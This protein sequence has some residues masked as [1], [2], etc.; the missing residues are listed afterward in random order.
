MSDRLPKV[1]AEKQ[2]K[3]EAA[4]KAA[5]G[6]TPE[7]EA[8]LPDQAVTPAVVDTAPAP[9]PGTGKGESDGPEGR[10]AT[11]PASAMVP[12]ETLS[13]FGV[14]LS[15]VTVQTGPGADK[16]CADRGAVAYA[17][18]STIVVS[19]SAGSPGS[20]EFLKI[21]GH[22]LTHVVQQRGGN[23]ED[24]GGGNAEA[25][26]D[27][28]GEAAAK[29][30]AASVGVS[31]PSGGEQNKEAPETHANTTV[32]KIP[33]PGGKSIEIEPPDPEGDWSIGVGDVHKFAKGIGHKDSKW[34]RKSIPTPFFGLV[35][36]VGA[37]IGMEFKLGEVALKGI[38]IAY[39]KA[40]DTYALEAEVGTGMSLEVFFAISAGVAAD[41]WVASAGIGLKAKASLIKN[42]PLSAKI[43]GS[44]SPSSGETKLAASLSLAALELAAK[45]SVALYVYYDAWL[46]STYTKEWT[47]VERTLGKLTFGGVEGEVSL[48]SSEGFDGKITPKPCKMQNFEGGISSL[49]PGKS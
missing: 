22:E 20:P 2:A 15:D 47:L 38:K 41:V 21:M 32:V 49:Y 26:A 48:S 37:E 19:S 1:S 34:W 39:K 25:E 5:S 28:A 33:L 27:S 31:A 12:A 29:G 23:V 30:E 17:A 18:G 43:S 14:D 10:I 40:T 35:A 45:A 8:A 7:T 4:A 24:G 42:H 9:V 13:A 36:E 3:R 16:Q 6:P 44:Y 11:E 46:V